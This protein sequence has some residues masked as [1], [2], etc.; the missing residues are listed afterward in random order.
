MALRRGSDPHNLLHRQGVEQGMAHGLRQMRLGVGVAGDDGQI[1][2]GVEIHAD[3]GPRRGDHAHVIR[4]ALAQQP[5]QAVV[6]VGSAD[7]RQGGRG[8]GKGQPVAGME[9]V[10]QRDARG[11]VVRSSGAVEDARHHG[12]RG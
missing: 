7:D 2:G 3:G 9:I 1:G 11:D 4:P 6:A 5:G 10:S 12:E 8:V